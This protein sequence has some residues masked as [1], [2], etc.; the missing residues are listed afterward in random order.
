MTSP[1]PSVGR[2]WL[3]SPCYA[4][5]SDRYGTRYLALSDCWCHEK[6]GVNMDPREVVD[7][8][9]EGVGLQ[10]VIGD[11]PMG[12]SGTVGR[13]DSTPGCIR[14]VDQGN[15][16]ADENLALMMVGHKVI[17]IKPPKRDQNADQLLL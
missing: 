8:R 2:R 4:Q 1:D 5:F 15:R 12:D 7:R 16:K 14:E 10:R 9:P 17:G 6:V 3:H 11:N 13:L